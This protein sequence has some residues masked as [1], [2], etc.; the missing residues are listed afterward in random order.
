MQGRAGTGP[1]VVPG[2]NLRTWTLR[3]RYPF[4]KLCGEVSGRGIQ[5]MSI[6]QAVTNHARQDGLDVF[7]QNKLTL[8]W[9]ESFPA[10]NGKN[11]YNSGTVERMFRRR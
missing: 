10:K 4:D 2:R 3:N 6:V 8:T 7:R 1:A 9:I 11:E 5:V